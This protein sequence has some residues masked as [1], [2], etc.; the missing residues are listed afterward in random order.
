MTTKDTK[1]AKAPAT[2][3]QKGK[4][5]LSKAAAK[6]KERLS[7]AAEKGRKQLTAAAEK[8]R[9]Q[10]ATVAEKGKQRLSKVTPKQKKAA[11]ATV[12]A[13]AGVAVAAAGIAAVRKR[14]KS[15]QRAI[16]HVVP[17]NDRWEVRTEGAQ[18]ATSVHE[19]KREAVAAAR[20][21]ARGKEPSQLVVHRLDGTVQDSFVYG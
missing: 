13:V 18:R 8:G 4:E 2:S 14:R 1:P 12:A 16:Y 11:A 10:I 20:Q 19:T 6:G 15:K 9:Q 3:A 7:T 21:L 17:S 5:R